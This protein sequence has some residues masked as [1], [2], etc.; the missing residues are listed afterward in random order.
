MIKSIYGPITNPRTGE[1]KDIIV[2][3]ITSKN[4]KD[5][6]I[7]S[8]IVLAGVAYLTL[9]TFKNGAN[10]FEEAEYK[11]LEELHLFTN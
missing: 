7:G 6:L 3:A 4:L 10:A 1:S 5:I 2:N 11:T 8:G 9:T